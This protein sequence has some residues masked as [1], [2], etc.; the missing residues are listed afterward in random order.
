MRAKLIP[1]FL[2]LVMQI[3]LSALTWSILG[4]S[5]THAYQKMFDPIS[6]RYVQFL[7]SRNF[8][9]PTGAIN[10]GANFLNQWAT[11]GGNRRIVLGA[12][13]AF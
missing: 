1:I 13:L 3:Q 12:R 10:S 2:G 9:I 11:N 8:G 5:K 4:S 7:N 6:S